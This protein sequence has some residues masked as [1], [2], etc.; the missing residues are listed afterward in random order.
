MRKEWDKTFLLACVLPLSVIGHAIEN[1]TKLRHPVC[2]LVAKLVRVN[3]YPSMSQTTISMSPEFNTKGPVHTFG[4]EN[5]DTFSVWRGQFEH[6][7]IYTNPKA[8][9][10]KLLG[11]FPLTA[12]PPCGNQGAPRNRLNDS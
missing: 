6:E 2:R 11:S 10:P 7:N 9:T 12:M 1:P 5:Q 8:E 3:V 4:C